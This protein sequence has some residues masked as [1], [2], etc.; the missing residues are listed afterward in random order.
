VFYSIL[1]NVADWLIDR[2]RG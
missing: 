1:T 2:V